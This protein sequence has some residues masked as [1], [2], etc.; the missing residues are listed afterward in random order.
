M[1]LIASTRF[2]EALLLLLILLGQSA[3]Q[4]QS[5]AF[6]YQGK[7]SDNGT[8]ANGAY[9]LQFKLFDAL[10]GGNQ[11]GASV[12][13]DD[14]AV[15]SGIFTV[16]LDF[17]AAAFPGANRWLEIGVRAGVSTGSFTT[18]SPLQPI[19][20]TPY[21]LQSL[22]A[23]TATNFSGPLV[24]VVT[25]TQAATALANNA[26]TTA[27]LADGSVTDAKITAVA[28]SK[29]TGTIPVASVPAG[30]TNYIQN[31][32]SLQAGGFNISGDGLVGGNVGI[33]ITPSAGNKLDVNGQA[34][35]RPG[36]S[37]GGFIGFGSPNAETGLTITGNGTNRADLR[38]NGST[39]KLVASTAG[40]PPE[41]NGI[42]IRTDGAVGIGTITPS[43]GMKLDVNGP[44]LFRPGGSGGGFINFHTPNGETGLTFNGNGT[45]RA[46][47]RFD[48][49]TL[50][51]VASTTGLPTKGIVINTFGQVGIGVADPGFSLHVED[52]S[53]TAIYGY[54]NC[55]RG[56]YGQSGG[57]GNGVE[58]S[59]STG[60]AGYFFG[61]VRVTGVIERFQD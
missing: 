43:V 56:V 34:L 22:N 26:V 33:G 11:I 47:I 31:T 39:L 50:K 2:I 49:A 1:N 13:R 32:A 16:T 29:L 24:G 28:A 40:I 36:G 5:T 7:L 15:A 44:V 6:T 37:G 57:A 4:A 48:S 41:T 25:G 51:L 35:F 45:T 42:A 60:Y 54:S 27:K 61:K 52:Q 21:A 59:S 38:F 10:A 9:D 12:V 20:S 19:T 8:A 14:V 17:G 58:G 30:S 46:D 18:L 55:C 3:I 53:S 23:A